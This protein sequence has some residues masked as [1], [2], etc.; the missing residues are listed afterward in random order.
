MKLLIQAV[1]DIGCVRNENEDSILIGNEVLL[2]ISK[3][4]EFEFDSVEYPFLIAVADGMG[5][6]K[7]GAYASQKV[8]N[9]MNQAIRALQPNLTLSDLK[10]TLRS[11]IIRIH[12]DLIDEGLKDQ[13]KVGMG[14]TF[15]GLL[16]YN[17]SIVMI[18]IGDSRLYRYRND[19]LT[20]LSKDHSLRELTN[21]PNAPR[22]I[23]LN[24]FGGGKNIFF[25]FEDLS[26][27][28]LEND[29]LLLCSD[30]LSGELSDEEIE[31]SLSD[32]MSL[33]TLLEKVKYFGGN[34]NISIVLVTIFQH[35]L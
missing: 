27:R 33:S 9:D 22:N 13:L 11:E 2:N 12:S 31:K 35:N 7:G 8:V 26:Q 5:G 21:D 3:E 1:S 29:T 16:F 25:D 4:Y 15:I 23:I 10:N 6:H 32:K 14:T 20:Q 18:N 28:T 24:S 19:T 34:D 17:N 30:G